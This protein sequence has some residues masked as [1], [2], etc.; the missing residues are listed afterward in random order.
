MIEAGL[1]NDKL[2]VETVSI[3][4]AFLVVM[5][6][7]LFYMKMKNPKWIT[8][9]LSLKSWV[10]A[11]PFVFLF[12]GLP[13]PW[14][15][16]GTI[17]AAVFGAKTFYRMTGMYHRTWFV[18]VTYALIWVQGYLVYNDYDRFFNILPMAFFLILTLVPIIKNSST[19]MIQFLA[20][21]LMS[22]IFFGWSF[23]HVGRMVVW[24]QGIYLIIYLFI[25][26]EINETAY[27]AGGRIFGRHKMLQNISSR[28]TV[29]GFIFSVLITV[30]IGW[31]LRRMLPD[32]SEVYWLTASL[33]IAVIG[34]VG[35]LLMS[36][37]R[38]DLGVK[39]S[40]VFIIGRDD[41]LGR[42]DKIMFAAPVIFYVYQF[43]QGRVAL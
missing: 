38:R 7:L 26:S 37:I 33:A 17:L 20:L 24:D 1:W 28:F 36:G 10:F 42:I 35:S 14:P 9:W 3:I 41:I 39:E 8:A 2:Y 43:L 25:L 19:Q 18:L 23:L 34:R 21:S 4:T 31:G 29:E 30:L 40:S 27:F 5:G 16:I 6:A 32:R 13:E 22:F 11:T 15:F 12:A